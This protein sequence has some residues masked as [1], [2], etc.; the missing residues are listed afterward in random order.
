MLSGVIAEAIRTAW[1]NLREIAILSVFPFVIWTLA[2][3]VLY[4]PYGDDITRISE[5]DTAVADSVYFGVSLLLSS[6]LMVRLHRGCLAGEVSSV[7]GSSSHL[8]PAVRMVAYTIA[9]FLVVIVPMILFVLVAGSIVGTGQA[10]WV[11]FFIALLVAWVVMVRLY[12]AFPAIS[13]GERPGVFAG[14]ALSRD[15]TV[16]LFFNFLGF[17]IICGLVLGAAL[18]AV[19]F[20]WI[21]FQPETGSM[22]PG[23]DLVFFAAILALAN[24]AGY[25]LVAVFLAVAYAR[26]SGRERPMEI[27]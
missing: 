23:G 1:S 10:F 14:W 6:W 24:V 3:A 15:N 2:F 22:L 12:V 25:A 8:A 27:H 9:I 7:A 16:A 11:L 19:M 18:V 5:A 26:L 17:S 20:V 13:L 4:S 21:Y